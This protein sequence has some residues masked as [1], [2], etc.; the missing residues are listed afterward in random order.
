MKKPTTT[1]ARPY[2]T[3]YA[4]AWRGHCNTRESAIMAAMRHLVTD[5]YT[6]ATVTN[7]QTGAVVA[8]LSLSDDRRTAKVETVTQLRKQPPRS[9]VPKTQKKVKPKKKPHLKLV[10]GGR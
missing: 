7:R 9:H 1:I 4:G 8:R 6:R 3:D 2:E 10:A 5:G